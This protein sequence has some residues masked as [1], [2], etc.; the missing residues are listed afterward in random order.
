MNQEL[1]REVELRTLKAE[2]QHFY[3]EKFRRMNVV[4][5]AQK[6][7]INTEEMIKATVERISELEASQPQGKP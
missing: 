5:Q 1:D 4:F 2:L 3:K 6:A 7:V